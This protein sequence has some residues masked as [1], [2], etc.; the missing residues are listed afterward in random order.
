MIS[1]ERY[2]CSYHRTSTALVS[3]MSWQVAQLNLTKEG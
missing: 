3:S 1:E 2:S